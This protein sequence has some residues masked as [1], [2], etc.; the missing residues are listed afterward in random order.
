M[1]FDSID[2]HS[3]Q[4]SNLHSPDD[5]DWLRESRR[6]NPEQIPMANSKETL[7][8]TP[9][10]MEQQFDLITSKVNEAVKSLNM[11]Y[12]EIGYSS[13]EIGEKKPRFSR[14][15]TTRSSPSRPIYSARKTAS[16]MNVNGS[17]SRFA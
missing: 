12:N 1:N 15:S 4:A 11:T 10:D 14:L 8:S 3:S 5:Q 9:L 7:P 6:L 2:T 13:K 17:G 16:A